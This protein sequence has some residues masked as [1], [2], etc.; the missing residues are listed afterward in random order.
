[1]HKHIC[2]LRLFLITP[3]PPWNL[4]SHCGFLEI[5]HL[6]VLLELDQVV[7]LAPELQGISILFQSSR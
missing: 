4:V 6:I 2:F 5:R 7:A 3:P 1:M